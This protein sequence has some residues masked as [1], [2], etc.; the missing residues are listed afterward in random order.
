ME[1]QNFGT[2][3]KEV[4]TKMGL[5]QKEFAKNINVT[6]SAL[7]SYEKGITNPSITVVT[8]IAKFS[9][10]STDWLLGL[11]DSTIPENNITTYADLF[12]ILVS[13]S[14]IKGFSINIQP[15]IFES[16]DFDDFV[17]YCGILFPDLDKKNISFFDDWA[18][19]LELFR[20][21]SIDEEVYDLWIEKTLNKY[22]FCPICEHI[23]F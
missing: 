10:V 9:K 3:L 8:E 4:R 1:I 20:N 17:Q 14:K 21:G 19:M 13:L 15:Y 16:R 23:D 7:S 18:K 5:S 6:A 2:R 12:K 11:S 22:R